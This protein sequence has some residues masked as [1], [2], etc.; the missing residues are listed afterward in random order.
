MASKNKFILDIR[1]FSDSLIVF[2]GLNK[3][4]VA[5]PK[6]NCKSILIIHIIYLNVAKQVLNLKG[7]YDKKAFRFSSA[8]PPEC[9]QLLN[10]LVTLFDMHLSERQFRFKVP[11]GEY[12]YLL[13]RLKGVL[14]CLP[15]MLY[16]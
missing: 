15:F 6:N 9:G 2:S 4:I 11:S 3:K 7:R 12:D 5:G 10:A 16:D 8:N 1:S 13:S 14:S